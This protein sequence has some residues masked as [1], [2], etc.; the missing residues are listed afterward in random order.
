MSAN[1]TISATYTTS[2]NTVI[3]IDLTSWAHL[4]QDAANIAVIQ[5]AL[6]NQANLANTAPGTFDTTWNEWWRAFSTDA[7]VKITITEV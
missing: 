4:T 2:D 7:N 5:T 6:S 3:P 1:V